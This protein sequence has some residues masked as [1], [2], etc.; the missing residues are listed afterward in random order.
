MT[1][2]KSCYIEK[3]TVKLTKKYFNEYEKAVK[4]MQQIILQ[5]KANSSKNRD[6]RELY[7]YRF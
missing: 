7:F 4:L 1:S 6:N 5:K 2:I 3:E